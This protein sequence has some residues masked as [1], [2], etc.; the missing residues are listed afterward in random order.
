MEIKAMFS[1]NKTLT[2][3]KITFVMGGPGSGKGTHCERLQREQG[4]HHISTGD[5]IRNLVAE[6]AEV[7]SAKMADI[8]SAMQRGELLSDEMI[9]DILANEMQKYPAAKHFLI[10]GY[11]RTLGQLALFEKNIG[12]CD[13]I[14]F[15]N[16]TVEIMKSR[17]LTRADVEHREDD[18]DTVIDHRIQVYQDKTLPVIH[19]LEKNK[20]DKFVCIDTSGTVEETTTHVNKAIAANDMANVNLVE[21]LAC[22]LQTGNF[23]D[24]I[25]TLEQRYHTLNFKIAMAFTTLFCVVQNKE[26]VKKVL[27][28][29][30]VAG[31]QNHNFDVSHGHL[32]NINA[33]PAFVEGKINPIW[34]GLHAGIL[35]SVGNAQ[36]IYHLVAKHFHHFL[37]KSTFSLDIAFE[38]FM[39][40][41]WCEFMFG[42]KV[43]AAKFRQTRHKLIS[44]LKYSYYDSKLKNIPY[45]GTQAC[46]LY[47][48]IKK[49]EF[50]EIDNELREFITQADDCLFFSIPSGFAK[51]CKLSLSSSGYCFIRQCVCIDTSIRFHSKCHV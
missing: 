38:T 29:N 48:F 5:L 26:D 15:F 11:P 9:T 45:I 24:V 13:K 39:E 47:G 3:A 28:A 32:L 42:S 31:F 16:T 30:T 12:Q 19:H 51:K 40:N 44:A 35:H 27:N 41:F 4:Y 17:L 36:G 7:N 8:R 2:Q 6:S 23:Y 21:F 18:K 33:V 50:A 43:D 46:K 14:L 22:Y 20:A 49:N 25:E 37:A 1:S 34:Q 10:D